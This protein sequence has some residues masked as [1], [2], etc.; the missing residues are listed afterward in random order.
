MLIIKHQ[1]INAF[2]FYRN[3]EKVT[4]CKDDTRSFFRRKKMLKKNFY[5]INTESNKF[6]AVNKN[7]NFI[8]CFKGRERARKR[9]FNCI[10]FLV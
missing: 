7:S 5:S 9:F 3:R 8:F 2:P 10:H 1:L 4:N 6:Y